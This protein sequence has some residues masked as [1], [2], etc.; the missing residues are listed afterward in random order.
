MH[1]EQ[2]GRCAITGIAF[3]TTRPHLCPSIDADDPALG[4]TAANCQ[5]VLRI[6]NYG[7][8]SLTTRAFLAF[9]RSEAPSVGY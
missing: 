6:V 1:D 4:H 2:D 9:L 7:K 8:N 5:I 3:D